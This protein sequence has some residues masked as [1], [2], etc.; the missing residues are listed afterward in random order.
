MGRKKEDKCFS[1]SARTIKTH[2]LQKNGS[3]LKSV[4]QACSNLFL[5]QA[6]AKQMAP[7][8]SLEKKRRYLTETRHSTIKRLY[9]C[10]VEVIFSKGV[11]CY[12]FFLKFVF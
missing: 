10:I 9:D 6:S 11:T 4:P 8:P 2:P 12:I 1:F 7:L 3:L 5:K